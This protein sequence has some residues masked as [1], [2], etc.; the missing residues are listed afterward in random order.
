MTHKL[1]H[2]KAALERILAVS[3]LAFRGSR[4]NGTTEVGTPKRPQERND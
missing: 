2:D 4:P 1:T 3:E